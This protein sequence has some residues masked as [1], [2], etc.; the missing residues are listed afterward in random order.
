MGERLACVLGFS[1]N[2]EAIRVKKIKLPLY[3]TRGITV[4]VITT[5]A[6]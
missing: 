4:V 3:K 6:S 5:D 1:I 2:P